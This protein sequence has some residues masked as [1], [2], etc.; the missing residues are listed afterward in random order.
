MVLTHQMLWPI[1]P[2]WPPLKTRGT[3][4]FRLVRVKNVGHLLKEQNRNRHTHQVGSGDGPDEMTC[5]GRK[6]KDDEMSLFLRQELLTTIT[7][8]FIR[9][10]FLVLG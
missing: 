7:N 2:R 4:Y 10:L 8:H 6:V 9:Y 3:R 1:A 5:K